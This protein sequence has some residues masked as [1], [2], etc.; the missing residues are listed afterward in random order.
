M[1][2]NS[3]FNSRK[4]ILSCTPGELYNFATDIRNF[5]QFIP[6][7]A[8]IRDMEMNSESCSFNIVSMGKVSGYL[9]EK[10]PF[11]KIVFNGTV[12]QENDFSVRMDISSTDEGKAEV[13]VLVEAE[14][15]P[16]L[17]MMVTNSVQSFLEKLISEMEAF[18]DWTPTGEQN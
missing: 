17:R 16:F 8:G 6:E 12:F 18:R 15:N 13:I 3:N 1:N 14:M 11:S 4:G 2:F 10:H 9:A 5:R 7:N